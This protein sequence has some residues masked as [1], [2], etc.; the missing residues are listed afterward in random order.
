MRRDPRAY[1][2][3]VRDASGLI[4]QFVRGTDFET[5]STSPLLRSAVERQFEIAGE[6]LSQLSKMDP[7]LA[8]RVPECRRI[9]AFRNVLI[10]GYAALDQHQIWRIIHESL[11]ALV[12]AVDALLTELGPPAA[13]PSRH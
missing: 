12:A 5:F 8:A 7:A 6:A 2:W 11:P 3:D 9:V 13:P 4:E 1:L 10:H